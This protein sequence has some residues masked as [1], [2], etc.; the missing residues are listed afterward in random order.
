VGLYYPPIADP[1]FGA[2]P[3]A[4]DCEAIAEEMRPACLLE[5]SEALL[6]AGRVDEAQADLR[7][8]LVLQPNNVDALAL[9]AVISVVRNEKA[10]AL[11]FAQE[12]TSLSPNAYRPW[13]ALSYAQQADFKL[14]QALESAQKAAALAPNSAWRARVAELL[15]CWAHP[16]GRESRPQAAWSPG[17]VAGM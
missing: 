1:Q 2:D 16:R 3:I 10:D 8:L 11:Q 15:M 7:D 17:R 5:R 4:V 12:A 13:L 6:R 9:R 14:E